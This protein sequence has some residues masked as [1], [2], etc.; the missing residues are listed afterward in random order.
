MRFTLV[1]G[2]PL[3][4][5]WQSSRWQS[6][7]WQ[8]RTRWHPGPLAPIGTRCRHP[9]AKQS[10]AKHQLAPVGKA[11]GGIQG[12]W[13][14]LALVV[15]TRCWH[16]LSLET[17]PPPP[18]SFKFLTPP[19]KSFKFLASPQQFQIS[20]FPQ[21]TSYF[22]PPPNKILNFSRY[23][24]SFKILTTPPPKQNQNSHFPFKVSEFSLPHSPI[25]IKMPTPQNI[26]LD[27]GS[28]TSDFEPVQEN[29]QITS[30]KCHSWT[31]HISQK[32]KMLE[33]TRVANP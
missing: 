11:P 17:F 8:W 20:H 24:T 6:T 26:I 23:L 27:F 3:A 33:K 7:R 12:C 21:E 31:F 1:H 13:H 30:G 25:K 18:K 22:S 9:S 15:G 29:P 10:L 14:P 4:T 5:R 28:S 16:P 2:N 19:F 32:L